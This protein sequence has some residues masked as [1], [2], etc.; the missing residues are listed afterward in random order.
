MFP[1][2]FKKQKSKKYSCAKCL[3]KTRYWC[4]TT[5]VRFSTVVLMV[6]SPVV[7]LGGD[8][9]FAV[10]TATAGVLIGLE[11]RVALKENSASGLRIRG[12]WTLVY[13]IMVLLYAL[14]VL[15]KLPQYTTETFELG[16]ISFQLGDLALTPRCEDIEEAQQSKFESSADS[17]SSLRTA[18][19][20]CEEL[21]SVH[22]FF[23][24]LLSV[25]TFITFWALRAFAND[26]DSRRRSSYKSV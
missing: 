13:S 6:V 7:L 17:T 10:I 16:T 25:F 4:T 26:V 3:S 5:F 21:A 15:F 23:L 14:M 12:W 11:S 2:A 1:R 20:Q 22:S 9:Y 18:A 19:Q 8:E 24:F